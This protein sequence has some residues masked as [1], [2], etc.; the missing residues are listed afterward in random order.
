MERYTRELFH[1]LKGG[2]NLKLFRRI[3]KSRI[4]RFRICDPLFA[5]AYKH[6][7]LGTIQL[8]LNFRYTRELF[9]ILKV[10]QS[11]KLFWRIKK[12]RIWRLRVCDPLFAEWH[13][14]QGDQSSKCS[15]KQAEE[16]AGE[17]A[18]SGSW[19]HLSPGGGC[20]WTSG[21][22]WSIKA[23]VRETI[24]EHQQEEGFEFL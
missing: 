17:W 23:G 10:G 7:F 4:W 13:L 20:C 5:V 9:N 8:D 19:R 24:Y 12:S 6:K 22:V 15:A 14:T 16:E 21:F 18:G 3:K 1:I 11:S 2:Q